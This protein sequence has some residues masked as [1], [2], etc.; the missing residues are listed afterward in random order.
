MGERHYE[1]VAEAAWESPPSETFR[2]S[3][4]TTLLDWFRANESSSDHRSNGRGSAV[5]RLLHDLQLPASEPLLP[6][7]YWSIWAAK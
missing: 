5:Q 7:S 6:L 1:A 4:E 2:P 3:P